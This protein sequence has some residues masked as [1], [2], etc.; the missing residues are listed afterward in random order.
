MVYKNG[1]FDIKKMTFKKGIE[2]T[3]YITQTIPFNFE[4]PLTEDTDYV[5]QNILKIC[6]N[7]EKH[8]DYFLSAIGYALTGD[9]SKEQLFWYLR[10]Q[11][12]DNGKSII[13]ETLEKL[14]PNYVT[15]ANSDVL[16]KGA[17]LRKEIASWKGLKL[18]WL[19][20]M[21]IKQ[22]D[23]DRVKALCDGTSYK[24]NR[25]YCTEAVVMPITFKLFTVSNNTLT[26]KGD[27]GIK[28]R[29]KL[30]QFNSQFK[31]DLSVDDSINLQFKKDKDFS[32]KLCGHY[33]NALIYLILT[34]SN[35]YYINN[36]LSEY[37]SE[38]NDEATEVI[39]DNNKFEEWF[40]DIFEINETGSI[41][42]NI[43]EAILN[44][45]PYKNIKIKDEFKRMKFKIHYDSQKQE[46]KDTI[47]IKGFWIG[48][49]L[50]NL[51]T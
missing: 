16:D 11:T 33:K 30:G 9:S 45:S 29:F 17:D 4:M 1:I 46:Y 31:E 23:E 48:F 37:P 24:Y 49:S 8:L 21:S 42:K 39:N 7:N 6:N 27:A 22:K 34:Y 28:R 5:K 36:A 38:W 40:L 15:K 13:F 50:T 41:H 25:L 44:N 26:I 51:K 12:A 32:N 18:L 3:D 35:K 47:R 43:F 2:Q 10:G 14:M 20:E 19:N